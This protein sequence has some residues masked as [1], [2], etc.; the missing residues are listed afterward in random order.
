MQS[1]RDGLI[2]ILYSAVLRPAVHRSMKG[3]HVFFFFFFLAYN[4]IVS[5]PFTYSCVK[6][7]TDSKNVGLIVMNEKE[8]AKV[9]S[10]KHVSFGPTTG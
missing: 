7:R 8:S 3:R 9:L 1:Q 5:I 4:V 6:G 2:P 10:S